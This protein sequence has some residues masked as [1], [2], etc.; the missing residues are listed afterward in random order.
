MRLVTLVSFSILTLLSGDAQPLST[1]P[2][3]RSVV[4]L[5]L[6]AFPAFALEDSR[7]PIPTLRKL[8]REGASA[9]RMIP[10]NPT[11][12]WPNHTTMV[13]GVLARDHGLLVNGT[14]V[15]QPDGPPKVDSE[16]SKEK[17]VH[18]TTVYDL[19]HRAGLTT[20]QIDWVA[21]NDAP[22]ITWAFPE[23]ASASDP[24][25]KEM[26]AKG[27]LN[28]DDVADKPART[29]LWRDQIWTRAATYLI[30]EHQPNLLLLHLLTLDSTQ[31]QYG[32]KTLAAYD[33]MAFLDGC[34]AQVVD[35]VKQSGRADRTTIFI[36]SDHG[37]K[38]VTRQIAM[39]AVLRASGLAERAHAIPEG[40]SVML[41]AKKKHDP[42]TIADLQRAFQ[43]LEGVD[44]IATRSD[45]P[46]LGLPD[47]E[48]D[49]QMAD[50][51][52][53]AKTGYG[54]S[55]A[56][57]DQPIVVNSAPTGSHAYLASDPDMH[58][59][60]IASGYGIRPGVVLDQIPN[61]RVAPT[62]AKMLGVDLGK[63]EASALTE[64]LLQ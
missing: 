2:V 61:T 60:F 13:T 9:K 20:A 34:V 63:T 15:P 40:G 8:A 7:L 49:P 27:A 35:A 57:S 42:Q 53:Y 23:K 10:I 51:M 25:V 33:A 24:L 6:D 44:R 5:S 22:A 52:I 56:K 17:M 28:P 58:A 11:I 50:V 55:N 31:H 30:R 47:P 29:I 37:F 4:V 48:K 41:Y 45:F 39:P 19:A 21:I 54:F 18:V 1:A 26:I 43:N 12:T 32:P 59:I 38:A 46:A 36:V 16:M 64:I 14:I 3:D 62:L